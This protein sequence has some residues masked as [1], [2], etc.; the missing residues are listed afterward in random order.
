MVAWS[1]L[2]RSRQLP[3]RFQLWRKHHRAGV[4]EYLARHYWWAYLTRGSVQ[5]F[6]HPAIINAILFG[7]YR[8]M[9][10]S[11]IGYLRDQPCGRFLQ[12]TCVYGELIP[13][14]YSLLDTTAFHLTDIAPVQLQAVKDKIDR[15]D[16]DTPFCMARTNVEAMP[17]AD[18][19]FDT[20]QI[21]FLLHELPRTARQNVLCEVLRV[22][23]PGGRLVIVEYG[24]IGRTHWLHRFPPFRWTLE[25]FEPYL[26]E[27]W[28]GSLKDQ[29]IGSATQVG[30]KLELVQEKHFFGGFYRLLDWE[31]GEKP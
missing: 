30:K 12:L 4:P 20:L 24:E 29:L 18:S 15:C 7:Q 26:G 10:D 16:A 8:A 25:F 31:C 13:N 17:Y 6:D 2:F 21:F 14:L 1:K 11:A 28:R 9:M 5:L 22:L 19:S 3:L 23:K 27:F